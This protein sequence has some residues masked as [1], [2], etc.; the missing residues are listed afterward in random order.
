M[1]A[2]ECVGPERVENGRGISQQAVA[3]DGL[4]LRENGNVGHGEMMKN[5][6]YSLRLP[7]LSPLAQK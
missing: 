3:R 6:W 5:A 1:I 4:Q 7:G 2:K